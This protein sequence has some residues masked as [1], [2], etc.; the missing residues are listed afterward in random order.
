MSPACSTA[1]ATPQGA[2]LPTPPSAVPPRCWRTL[3]RY[4]PH[5][6]ISHHRLRPCEE[7]N[8]SFRWKDSRHHHQPRIMTLAAAE[9]IRRFLRPILPA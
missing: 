1:V 2:S 3:G 7:G 8:V 5:V 6:A 9:F 4:T